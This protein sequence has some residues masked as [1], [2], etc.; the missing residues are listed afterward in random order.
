MKQIKV[1]VIEDHPSAR[2]LY[3]VLLEGESY[4]VLEASDGLEGISIA[5]TDKPDLVILDLMIPGLGGESV[6]RKFKDTEALRTTPILVVSAKDDALDGVRDLVGDENV[7]PK[8][9]E[10]TVLLDRVGA[11]VGHPDDES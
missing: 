11:L 3:K 10:P 4:E 9:F 7:F 6:I 2:E 8:P 1:L 5:A